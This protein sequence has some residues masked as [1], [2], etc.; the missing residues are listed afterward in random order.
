MSEIANV[1][2]CPSFAEMIPKKNIL[3]RE[4]LL[5][6]NQ[7]TTFFCRLDP[8]CPFRSFEKLGIIAQ[9]YEQ[10][11]RSVKLTLDI[12]GNFSFKTL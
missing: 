12:L 1:E 8:V 5:F 6:S 4:C 9:Q 10:T 11:N 7:K 2:A 3:L